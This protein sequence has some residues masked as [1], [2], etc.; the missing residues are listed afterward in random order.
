MPLRVH[1]LVTFPCCTPCVSNTHSRP[2]VEVETADAQFVRSAQ[3]H[4]VVRREG[5][6]LRIYDPPSESKAAGG[7]GGAAQQGAEPLGLPIREYE[8][9]PGPPNGS[10]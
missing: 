6:P 3:L 1:I 5:A 8:I 2:L 7:G 9:A 10:K 4:N